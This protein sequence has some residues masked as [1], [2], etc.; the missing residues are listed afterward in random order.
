[1]AYFLDQ[2]GTCILRASKRFLAYY[3]VSGARAPLPFV[4]KR[5]L[6]GCHKVVDWHDVPLIQPDLLRLAVSDNRV[7]VGRANQKTAN[8]NRQTETASMPSA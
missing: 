3:D 6:A 1:V 7:T 2:T 5:L 8:D 4:A